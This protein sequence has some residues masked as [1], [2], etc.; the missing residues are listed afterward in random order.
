MFSEFIFKVQ[1]IEKKEQDQYGNTT[2][3]TTVTIIVNDIDDNPPVFE[4]TEYIAYV[5]ENTPDDSLLKFNKTITVY[6][7]DQVKSSIFNKGLY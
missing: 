7:I 1:E 2:A 5:K 6:D 3:T 4:E